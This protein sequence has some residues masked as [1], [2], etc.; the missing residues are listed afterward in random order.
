M[1]ANRLTETA[2]Q[3]VASAQQIAQT[4][5]HASVTPLHLARALLADAQQPPARVLERAGGDLAQAQA[6]LDAALRREPAVSGGA[7]EAY[8]APRP[9]RPSRQAEAVARPGATPS[10]PP[11]PARRA[12]A[13][14]GRR[15]R[16]AAPGRRPRARRQ[17]VRAGQQ[18]DSRTAE[19]R[20]EALDK[21]GI[22]L[23]RAPPRASS[24]R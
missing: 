16:H 15:A 19:S 21:Y 4:R 17:E 18:V 2:L 24:T 8:L 14:G 3:L 20:F 13:H 22:D 12:A 5:R 10:S 6:A 23:T 9:P 7:G 11:T 1:D